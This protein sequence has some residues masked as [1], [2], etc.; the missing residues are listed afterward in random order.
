MSLFHYTDA[1]AVMK[2][3]ETQELWLTDIR[4]LNDSAEYLHGVDLFREQLKIIGKSITIET[5]EPYD[6][7]AK[8]IETVLGMGERAIGVCSFSN[9][10]DLLSQWR[11]YGKYAIEFDKQKIRDVAQSKLCECIYKEDVQKKTTETEID[12]LLDLMGKSSSPIET[13]VDQAPAL[14][15]IIASFKNKGFLEEKEWRL[16][17]FGTHENKN[18]CF[19]ER[20]GMLVPYLKMKFP[21]EA[22]KRIWVGPM[23]NQVLSKASMQMYLESLKRDAK[24][25]FSKIES[26]PE[27]QL[28]QISFRG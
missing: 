15:A 7:I 12:N 10:E 19:R 11:G 3:L 20:N 23:Q 4:Y 6:E 17:S 24:N 28:S 25:D 18:Y 26:L 13:L 27:I 5:Q 1:Y 9:A 8:F 14:W 16:I 2:I 21:V 22:I